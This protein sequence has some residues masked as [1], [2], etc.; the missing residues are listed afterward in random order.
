MGAGCWAVRKD[1][2]LI[3]KCTPL[4]T[5]TPFISASPPPPAQQMT[6]IKPSRSHKS[7]TRRN[8]W[9][10]NRCYFSSCGVQFGNVGP[11]TKA[12]GLCE[13][14]RCIQPVCTGQ[15]RKSTTWCSAKRRPKGSRKDVQSGGWGMTKAW[16]ASLVDHPPRATAAHP[17]RKAHN[18]H[19]ESVAGAMQMEG[20]EREG[21]WS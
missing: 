5:T 10:H 15:R 21:G 16:V 14:L 3:R 17:L 7:Q 9:R 11:P 19:R 2:C 20:E 12:P 6:S 18:V 1:C 13:S 4:H 8:V